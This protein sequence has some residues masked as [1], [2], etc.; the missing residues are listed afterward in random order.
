[1]SRIHCILFLKAGGFVVFLCS[2]I[3]DIIYNIVGVLVCWLNKTKHLSSQL[4]V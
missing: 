3:I 2:I 4:G 1:M